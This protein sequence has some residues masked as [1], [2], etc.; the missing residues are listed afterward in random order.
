MKQKLFFKIFTIIY[1]FFSF[2]NFT[3]GQKGYI[4]LHKKTTGEE[5]PA[6]FKFSIS[7]GIT[8]VNDVILNDQSGQIAIND[9]GSSQSGTLWA[10]GSDN[11]VYKRE[12]NSSSWVKTNFSS[13]SRIDGGANNTCYIISTN[14]NVYSFDGIISTLIYNGTN[15]SDIGSA[16]DNTP[17]IVANSSR[18]YKYTGSG[19]SGPGGTSWLAYDTRTDWFRI[20]GDPSTGLPFAINSTNKSVFQFS[21]VN[22]NT[23]LGIPTGAN[24][25]VR[26]S[27]LA[28]DLNGKLYSIFNSNVATNSAR[29]VFNYNVGGNWTVENSSRAS[30][31]ITGGIGGQIWTIVNGSI[32]SRTNNNGIIFWVDNEKL[33][34]PNNDCA[35]MLEVSQGT[36]SITENNLS[37][38]LLSSIN[39][40]DP[41]GNSS[42]SVLLKTASL[43]VTAGEVVHVEFENTFD[44]SS[45][46]GGN[47]GLNIIQNFGTGNPIQK[48][49]DIYSTIPLFG[50]TNYH[51][52]SGQNPGG[53]G[54]YALVQNTSNWYIQGNL[55]DHTS[56]TNGQFLIVNAS[57]GVDEFFRQRVTGLVSGL[58]YTLSFWAADI[59]NGLPL[60]PSIIFGIEDV[61][62][63]N[64]LA[65]LNTGN[66][67]NKS[68]KQFSMSFIAATSEVSLYIRNNGSGG[69]GNDIAID[70]IGFNLSSPPAPVTSVLNNTCSS[71]IGSI[72]INSPS[73][74][75][76]VEFSIDGLNYQSSPIFS[77]LSAGFYTINARYLNTN[78]A[79]FKKDTIKVA[80]CG[81]LFQDDNALTDN[82]VNGIGTNAGG[83]KG[84]L[85]DNTLKKVTSFI[86]IPANGIIDF[87]GI[88]IPDNDYNV[89][90]TNENPVLGQATAPIS[91]LPIGYNNTGEHIGLNAGNDGAVN[92]I[93]PLGVVSANV[94]NANLGI[95][96]APETAV[97]LQP[98]QVN[99]GG[100]NPVTVPQGAFQTSNVSNNPNTDDPNTGIVT[101]INIPRFPTNTT[102]ITVNGTT[103]TASS[104]IW[105][106][107]GITIPYTDGIGPTLVISL[108]PTDGGVNAIIPIVA[109]DNT[110][111]IDPSPGSV[112]I[113]FSNPVLPVSLISF[114][115]SL[116][117]EKVNLSWKVANETSFSHYLLERSQNATEFGAFG[118]VIAT[119]KTNYNYTDNQP[120]IGNNYYRLRMVDL[121]GTSKV[122]KVI[123]IKFE[124]NTSFITIENPANNGEFMVST[125]MKNASFN[126][127]NSLGQIIP[128]TITDMG[129]NQFKMKV[130]H[131][132]SGAY[133][134][135]ILSEGKSQTK[136]VIM[137]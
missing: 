42:S 112:T 86:N 67:S 123:N 108:D 3:K 131:V 115:A 75:P 25:S 2:V 84:V 105:G 41:T 24:G 54:S 117:N 76:N 135:N 87:G 121:D 100:T 8:Q 103:Y 74:P 11:I 36:Y 21:N 104:P 15:A 35:V 114:N 93:L 22:T 102:S 9:I 40:Y 109:I 137:P 63:G 72:T 71:T 98:A 128:F 28:I 31:L 111:A 127:R 92:G 57:Y 82:I 18:I 120:I 29:T 81:K 13:A 7:G 1:F 134:L 88:G 34:I 129:N 126:L 17:Y 10:I 5:S 65:S 97:N 101:Q 96:Q 37:G 89:Y 68:W 6:N 91:L 124:K 27:D 59:S 46:I 14:G 132:V 16:W 83:I 95:Q 51:F 133:Y 39:I 73:S 47:C 119:G 61:P 55:I 77:G 58:S 118:K 52:S 122:S 48:T 62:T 4:Y 56:L 70:D 44:I 23:N 116:A 125:N 79:S 49:S 38:W 85:Y 99:P 43:N 20:D 110:G 130:L 53:D 33:R 78:C 80:I 32:F 64:N 113:P 136:K 106:T 50:L 19:V 66:I 69:F 90:I 45:V 94:T 60:S 107:G 30:D 12:L 26:P